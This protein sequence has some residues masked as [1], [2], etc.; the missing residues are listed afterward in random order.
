MHMYVF[1]SHQVVIWGADVGDL[2]LGG[3]PL[4]WHP[5]RRAL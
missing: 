2:H 4:P 3:L 5:R 1:V